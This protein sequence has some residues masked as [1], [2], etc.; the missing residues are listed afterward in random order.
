MKRRWLGIES[1]SPFFGRRAIASSD[2][3]TSKRLPPTA[4]PSRHSPTL[5]LNSTPLSMK[6]WSRQ[7]F[8][9]VTL[10]L[11][12]N[13]TSFFVRKPCETVDSA[14]Y[15]FFRF[16][17]KQ[18]RSNSSE[19]LNSSVLDFSPRPSPRSR[20]R[21]GIILWD[22]YPGLRPLRVLTPGYYLSPLRPT[23]LGLVSVALLLPLDL[24]SCDK[25]SQSNATGQ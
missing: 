25:F 9:L 11:A 20:R 7:L 15:P 23:E 21:G 5:K 12:A 24:P 17:T 1:L 8:V 10:L 3:V 22:V 14:S 18:K 2:F 6:Q 19:L 16:L 4:Q 13:E